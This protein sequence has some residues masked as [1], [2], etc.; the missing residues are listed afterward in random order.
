MAHISLTKMEEYVFFI[1]IIINQFLMCVSLQLCNE[2]LSSLQICTFTEDYM[3]SFPTQSIKSKS[4]LHQ[5]FT[6]SSVSDFDSKH[7]TLTIDM[8]IKMFWNDS[9]LTIRSD[10]QFDKWVSCKFMVYRIDSSRTRILTFGGSTIQNSQASPLAAA[11]RTIRELVLFKSSY[12]SSL[13]GK[14][15]KPK[16]LIEWKHLRSL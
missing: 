9:R 1:L 5:L 7:N 11:T 3:N 8:I 6:I 4:I 2:T 15:F 13:Y 12:I 14:Y 10:N 16:C